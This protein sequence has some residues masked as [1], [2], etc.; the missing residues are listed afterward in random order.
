MKLDKDSPRV[1]GIISCYEEDIEKC[2]ATAY[3]IAGATKEE[4]LSET[5]DRYLVWA[6]M[7]IAH[8]LHKLIYQATIV[9]AILNRTHSQVL[10][11]GRKF[12]HMYENEL[13]FSK[14]YDRFERIY[15][16]Q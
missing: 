5:R 9:G 16:Q 7:C 6:R 3:L 1:V 13:G 15:S 11:W 8:K 2:F 4:L 12:D 10:Y 14:F